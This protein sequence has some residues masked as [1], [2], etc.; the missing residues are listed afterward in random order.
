[1]IAS[2]LIL[3]AWLW[4]NWSGAREWEEAKARATAAGVPLEL[5]GWIIEIPEKENLL[6]DPLVHNELFASGEGKL[7]A[8]NRLPEVDNR[9]E[10]SSLKPATGAT[11]DYRD[12][13]KEELD[14]E[15]ATRKLAEAA[16]DFSNRLDDL[17]EVILSKPEHQI[18]VNE[19]AT[20]GIEKSGTSVFVLQEIAACYQ[21]A[22]VMSLRLNDPGLALRY[23]QVIDRLSKISER[24]SMIHFLISGVFKI[25][26]FNIIW[27]G[28]RLRVWRAGD[29]DA[30]SGLLRG[31]DPKGNLRNALQFE[32]A[33][34]LEGL[35]Q[36]SEEIKLVGSGDEFA[37]FHGFEG[38]LHYGGFAG[39]KD[40]RR[41]F[42][43][44]SYLDYVEE[45]EGRSHPDFAQIQTDLTT[46]G[47]YSPLHGLFDIILPSIDI[48][49]QKYL[50]IETRR[51]T[52]LIAISLEGY[53]QEHQSYPAKLADLEAEFSMID[54][55]DPNQKELAY[56]LGKDGRPEIW[57]RHDAALSEKDRED[58]RWQ[59]WY[60]EPPK[61]ISYRPRRRS[62][63]DQSGSKPAPAAKN[64]A[65]EER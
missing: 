57:S 27:E 32:I 59:F 22:A 15:A 43:V 21:S 65:E 49:C 42:I 34:S 4:I 54:S 44:N 60:D 18:F 55:T 48:I 28:L 11:L 58:L 1:M 52:A 50:E 14:E 31:H 47:R 33:Y 26:E 36:I 5:S 25:I 45:L 38:W 17:A 7:T 56:Q 53:Y 51:R 29:L 41:A 35:D 10:K 9:P 30:L 6:N 8:W 63:R 61:K 23:A 37:Q 20:G 2:A 19:S 16:R 13:F 62:S 12:Y 3:A 40:S 64:D 46:M 39:W 24:P